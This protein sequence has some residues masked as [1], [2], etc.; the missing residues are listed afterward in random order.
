[1]DVVALSGLF[2]HEDGYE[3]MQERAKD[4]TIIIDDLNTLEMEEVVE[5][6]HPEIVLGGIKEKYFFH[7]LGVSSVMIHSYE[8]GPY[9]GFEGFVNLAKDIYTAI[10]NPAWSLMEFEDEEPGDTNE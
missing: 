4:G 7:K 6:Y 10:Y 8:N 2:E 3:K 5:K 1:M 9:I